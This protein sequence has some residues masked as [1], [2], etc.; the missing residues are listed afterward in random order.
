[1]PEIFLPYRII[2]LPLLAKLWQLVLSLKKSQHKLMAALMERLPGLCQTN[3]AYP[4]I[5]EMMRILGTARDRFTVLTGKPFDSLVDF[6]EV[7]TRF[8]DND[9]CGCLALQEFCYNQYDKTFLFG[10]PSQSR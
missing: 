10:T 6:L 1:L 3:I 9:R 7:A 4:Q 2:S 8:E 5:Q